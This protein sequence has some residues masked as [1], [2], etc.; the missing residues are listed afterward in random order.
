VR[1][2]SWTESANLGGLNAEVGAWRAL[3]GLAIEPAAVFA[4]PASNGR[5]HVRISIARGVPGQARLVMAALFAIPRVKHVFVV[6]DDVDVFSDE[7]VEWAMASRFRADRDIVVAH[8]FPVHSIDPIASGDGIVS[9]AGFDLTAPYGRPDRI[10][11]RRPVPPR[12]QPR[13]TTFTVREALTAGPRTFSDIMQDVG[14]TDGREVALELAAMRDAGEIRRLRDG[15]WA[16][17]SGA[18]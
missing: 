13:T 18:A 15:E 9:K 3:R 6:D 1:R 10:E 8:G 5:Q 11:Y 16:L 14:S 17:G 2:L 12:L 7:E 4:V